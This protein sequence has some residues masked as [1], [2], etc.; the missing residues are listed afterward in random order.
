MRRQ[1]ARRLSWISGVSDDR[2]RD[3]EHVSGA[4]ADFAHEKVLFSSRSLRAVTSC[5][6]PMKVASRLSAQPNRRYHDFAAV[7]SIAAQKFATHAR[8]EFGIDRVE[9]G[10]AYNCK[11]FPIRWVDLG[12]EHLGRYF[13]LTASRIS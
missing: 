13:G 4:T 1:K 8:S 3:A 5:G 7:L 10:P 9:R 2:G 12:Q 6:A 11:S